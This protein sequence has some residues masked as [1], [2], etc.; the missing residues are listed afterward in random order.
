MNPDKDG[1][2]C[3]AQLWN[4]FDG[5]LDECVR[6]RGHSGNHAAERE[7][8]THVYWRDDGVDVPTGEPA[9]A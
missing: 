7:D 6:K 8:G 3:L 9:D 4:D 5:W 2:L 1:N